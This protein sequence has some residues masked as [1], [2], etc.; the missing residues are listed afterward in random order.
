LPSCCGQKDKGKPRAKANILK[1]IGFL[2][3][4]QQQCGGGCGG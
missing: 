3:R 1:V 4:R 2:R